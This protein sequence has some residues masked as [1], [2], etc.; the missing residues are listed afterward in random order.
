MLGPPNLHRHPRG[1]RVVS[2]RNAV[3]D[4]DLNFTE[5]GSWHSPPS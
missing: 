2:S 1:E 3:D 5:F 4:F